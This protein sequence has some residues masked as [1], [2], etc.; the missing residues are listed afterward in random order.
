M[1]DSR[2]PSTSRLIRA[3]LRSVCSAT[4]FPEVFN[5]M[6]ILAFSVKRFHPATSE[7]LTPIDVSTS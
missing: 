6:Q 1:A 2:L 7:S 4:V 3:H 5:T